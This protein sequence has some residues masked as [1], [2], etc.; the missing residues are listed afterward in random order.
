MNNEQL[1]KNLQTTLTM[2]WYGIRTEDIKE[3]GHTTH[4]YISVPESSTI[5]V[6][7]PELNIK[8]KTA[9]GLMSIGKDMIIKIILD[10][11][12]SE[13][14]DEEFTKEVKDNISEYLKVYAKVRKGEVWTEEMGDARLKEIQAE[15]KKAAAYEEV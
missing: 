11:C 10:S 14:N 5:E 12:Q 3:I 1:L 13:Y 4:Q 9:K 6:D 15:A 2:E 7:D 8:V